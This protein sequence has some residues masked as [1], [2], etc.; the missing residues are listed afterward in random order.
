[1]GGT[2]LDAGIVAQGIQFGTNDFVV[3]LSV[4]QK[5]Y[6]HKRR[7]VRAKTAIVHQKI[8]KDVFRLIS[9]FFEKK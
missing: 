1:M 7:I 6:R 3:R 4:M 2:A 9:L 8:P 5:Q